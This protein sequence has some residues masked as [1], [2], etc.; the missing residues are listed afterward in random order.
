MHEGNPIPHVQITFAPENPDAV[1][2]PM[3]MADENGEFEMKC[4]RNKGVP[5]GRYFIHIED[6]AEADGG[7]TSTEPNYLF[8]VDRFSP[9][10]SDLMYDSDQHRTGWEM[11]LPKTEYTG[12]EVKE[13]T[14]ENTTDNQ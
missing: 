4:G 2:P 3:A 8:V 6:P 1:R 5:P 9:V 11:D 10:K 7:Q 13:E 12:P 14:M